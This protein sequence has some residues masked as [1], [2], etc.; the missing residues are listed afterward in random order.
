MIHLVTLNPA[1]DLELVLKDPLSG[2][3][4]EVLESDVEAGGKALNV[5]RF[6]RKEKIKFKIWLGTGG[7]KHPTHML[8]RSLIAREGLTP[9]YLSSKAPVRLNV[10]VENSGKTRKYNH[11]GFELDLTDFGRLDQGL[12]KHDLLVMT[13][14]LPHG[15]NPELYGSWIRVFGRKGV[16]SLVDSSGLALRKALEARPWFFK[17]NLFEFS[18]ALGQKFSNLDQVAS[19]LPTFLKSGL[20]H[21]SVTNGLE[22]ALLWNGP[23]ACWV[24]SSQKIKSRL[25][26]GAGDGFLAGY[27]RGLQTRKS[28]FD[29]ARLACATGTAVAK[30]GIMGF[31]PGLVSKL[32]KSVKVTQF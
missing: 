2:K 24:R 21:G 15:M 7:G 26:V 1:L 29:C 5:A 4:G 23:V 9:Y 14:R 11:P 3:I 17:V 27:I 10:V 31:D 6:L 22:G 13:G 18:G 32:L 20:L 16:R 28:F 30:T 8:Y 25:V 19:R 12:K